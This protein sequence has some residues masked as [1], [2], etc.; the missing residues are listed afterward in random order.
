MPAG[1]VIAESIRPGSQLEGLSFTLSRI[2]RYTVDNATHDQPAAW[3][4]IHFEFP[5]DQVEAVA[6]ALAEVL[7]QPGWYTN[8][9]TRRTRLSS[10]PAA[11]F[12]T[13]AVIWQHGPKLKRTPAL[14]ASR[15]R[16]STGRQLA[17]P[18]P[19][20]HAH[21]SCEPARRFISSTPA[22]LGF[23]LFRSRT[24]VSEPAAVPT[25]RQ[26]SLR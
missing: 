14:S 25:V 23:G 11:S 7:D 6:N 8:F 17:I 18:S 24:I 2:E 19:T 9:V 10:S 16:S 21:A 15:G 5:E 22:T 13:R 1:Y 26:P 12:N 20:W 4:M 3:T